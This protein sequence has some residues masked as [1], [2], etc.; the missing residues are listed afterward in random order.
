LGALAN[1]VL[2]R[3]GLPSEPEG[4]VLDG[5]LHREQ[6]HG[7]CDSVGVGNDGLDVDAIAVEGVGIC[8]LHCLLHDGDDFRRS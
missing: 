4:Y 3:F 6:S 1:V 7:G 2:H 8:R 5:E